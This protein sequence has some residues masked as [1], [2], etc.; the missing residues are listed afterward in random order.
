MS[1]KKHPL[2]NSWQAM[3]VRCLNPNNKKYYRYGGRGITVCDRWMN[4]F[5]AFVEDMG[6]RPKGHSL[7]R[8]DNDGNYTPEN[9][10]WAT[11]KQQCRNRS[12]NHLLVFNGKTQTLVEWA[13]ELGI[14][15][16]LIKNR[17]N[18]GWSTEK[19]FTTPLRKIKKAKLHTFNGETHNLKY[20]AEK[21]N[22]P[23]NTLS[24]RIHRS[25]WSIEKALNEPVRER[26]RPC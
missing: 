21:F 20:W 19:I 26:G 23:I 1:N 13:E 25:G 12:T 15:I 14:S 11:H 6:E 2:Y 8:I 9:C 24:N 16:K 22:I 18:L 5:S 10:R 4:N 7:D 3:K 17:Q